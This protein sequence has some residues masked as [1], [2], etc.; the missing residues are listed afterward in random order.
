MVSTIVARVDDHSVVETLAKES[1]VPV[2]NALSS[3]YHPL[4]ALADM[5]TIQ[6]AF[7][8]GYVGRKVAWVGDATNVLYDLAI[9]A[10]KMG[11]N[12][13]AATPP[14]YPFNED[15]LRIVKDSS[16]EGATI[17]LT[18]DPLIAVHDADI[19][20]TD[21][22]FHPHKRNLTQDFHGPRIRKST[23]IKRL[24]R[25]PSHKRNGPPRRRTPHLEIHALSPP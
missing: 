10:V 8:E 20:V 11:I 25:L 19:I 7:P 12:V 17:Q 23:T 16:Q 9:A 21:T 15:V 2:I 4:Q 6:E 24:R 22:W 1:S 13:S 3:L 18:S 14:K 5:L